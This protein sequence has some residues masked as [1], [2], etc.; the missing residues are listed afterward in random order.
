MFESLCKS[1]KYFL[2]NS[3]TEIML[4]STVRNTET[5][6]T[7]LETLGKHYTYYVS[8]LIL[9][10]PFV[11]RKIQL[12]FFRRRFASQLLNDNGPR[13]PSTYN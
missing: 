13:L 3:T 9:F 8:I 12:R 10:I 5:H 6:Q 1:L 2:T 4:F 11:F 7:F